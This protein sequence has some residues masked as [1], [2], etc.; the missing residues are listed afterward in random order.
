M[1]LF[2]DGPIRLPMAE[3]DVVFY[4]RFFEPEKAEELFRRL[5]SE[6]PWR[7]V[8]I[9]LYG[10][11]IPVPR[12]TAWHGDPG[13]SYTYSKLTLNAEPWTPA[14]LEIRDRLKELDATDFNGVLL[15]S[16]RNGNDGMSWHS[17]DEPE[18]GPN[19][20]IASV[21]FGGVRR[22]QF[23]HRL[24]RNETAAIDLTPGSCLMMRGETQTFWLH[25]IPKTKKSC[26]P[27]INLTFRHIFAEKQGS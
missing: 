12:L 19:P 17:D 24:R 3:A 2:E 20:V 27:R 8:S 9:K 5:Q 13:V 16:Y 11:T 6:I 22:F 10:K 14:L 15:N 4:P 7:Q 26:E 25:Q 23:R 18:L 1:T 21:N